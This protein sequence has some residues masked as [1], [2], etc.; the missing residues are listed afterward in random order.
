MTT[1]RVV[2]L[3]PPGKRLYV[4]DYYCSKVSKSNYLFH[5]IDLLML[6][7]RL[8]SRY[9]THLIDA[10][11]DGLT[12][13]SCMQRL[14]GIAPT[15]VISLIG[16]V[17]LGE[18]LPFLQ[19]LK[20]PSMQLIV[21]GDA[22]LEDPYGWLDAHGF[23]DAVL[24]DFTSEGIVDY[25]DGRYDSVRGIAHRHGKPLKTSRA[26]N[27]GFHIPTP[28][29]QLFRSTNYR[30][31]F[32]RHGNFATVL[33][34]Y[35]CPFKCSF[36]VM[37]GIGYRYRAVDN[38]MEELLLL[39]VLGRRE[40]FFIDQ[41]FGVNRHRAMQL[42]QEMTQAGLGLGW[43]C[44]SR[45]DVIDEQ[46]LVTMKAAGCH[47]IILGVESASDEVLRVYRKGYTV[48]QIRQAFALCRYHRVRTVATVIIGLPEETQG[49]I[50]ATVELLKELDC[51]F[52]SFNVAV[53]RM[54][55][56]L[57]RQAITEGLIDKD[58]TVMDQSGS[59]VV[60]PTRHL[61]REQLLALKSSAIRRFY[62]RPSYLYK[63]LTGIKT[64]YEFKEQVSEGLALLL[65]A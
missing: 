61:S 47:T 23:V 37:S 26:F 20:T 39:R 8:A 53:P 31:P 22:A 18:D 17:S 33:T 34:D 25:I 30:F 42:C 10:I 19:R 59:S 28:R 5:P 9:E 43:V 46:L 63:R 3:N 21:S 36:C 38:V 45:A 44:Y 16:A 35:G 65:N 32:V 4:R 13:R 7:G 50:A 11:A 27:E 41:T 2:L 24:L 1:P 57:R 15:I 48:E 49:S 29:H 6:S 54:S 51:D 14:R 55:T 62:L 40:V 52:A 58:L 64:L 12:E 60:M 56:P